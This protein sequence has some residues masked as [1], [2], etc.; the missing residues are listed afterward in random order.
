MAKPLRRGSRRDRQDADGEQR[1]PGNRG[2]HARSFRIPALRERERE[3]FQER[4]SKVKDL[5]AR[6]AQRIGEV[7][8]SK[9][10]LA[11]RC[12]EAVSEVSELLSPVVGCMRAE[13]GLPFDVVVFSEQLREG[14][15]NARKDMQAYL[16]SAHN[17]AEDHMNR[18]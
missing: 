10:Q 18:R 13:L 15:T 16:H 3:Q 11:E 6:H 4:G 5:L 12:L 14:L 2:R 9:M 1:R 7:F 8:T 17:I